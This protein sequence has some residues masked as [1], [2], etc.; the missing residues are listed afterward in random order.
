MS[1]DLQLKDLFVKEIR[2]CSLKR[3][4]I[5]GGNCETSLKWSGSSL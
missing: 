5:L 3:G 4:D 2:N 1:K